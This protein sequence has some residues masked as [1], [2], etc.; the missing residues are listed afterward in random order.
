MTETPLPAAGWYPDP[1]GSGR[2]RWW[3]GTRWTDNV[4]VPY[5]AAVG[6]A[7]PDLR[8]PDATS[9]HTFWIWAMVGLIGLLILP[10]FLVDYSTASVTPDQVLSGD[11]PPVTPGELAQ[12]ALGWLGAALFVLFGV[13]DYR[14]LSAR[15]VPKPF[16][17]AWGF[18]SLL[19]P[20]VYI[21]GRSVVVKRR[22]GSGLSPI[23]VAVA[24]TLLSWAV[25]IVLLAPFIIASFQAGYE[26]GLNY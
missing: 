21:I 6:G 23:W 20:L 4:Q 15:G 1:A 25:T 16:H 19:T 14:A 11:Y 5:S 9:P 3:D 7:A 24:L 22:T 10:S 17:W 2:S 8:A 26:A 13:L 12:T 18:F